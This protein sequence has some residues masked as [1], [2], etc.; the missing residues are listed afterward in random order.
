[1][2]IFL[3]RIDKHLDYM[4]EKLKHEESLSHPLTAIPP[5]LAFLDNNPKQPQ[6]A[7]ICNFF[8]EDAKA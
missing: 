6:K 5:A 3:K 2:L 4:L 8:T 7:Q 1:M